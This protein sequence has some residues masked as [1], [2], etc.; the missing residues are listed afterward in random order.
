MCQIGE[1]PVPWYISISARLV[2]SLT[3]SKKYLDS[4]ARCPNLI[5]SNFTRITDTLYASFRFMATTSPVTPFT[6]PSA[7]STFIVII[8]RAQTATVHSLS[9]PPVSFRVFGVFTFVKPIKPVLS[10]PTTN[11][12]LLL[13]RGNLVQFLF[14][15]AVDSKVVRKYMYNI[16]LN[17]YN[18]WH[19]FL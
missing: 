6:K 15:V 11:C 18:Y 12:Y 5:L 16:T 9:K 17:N 1:A 19:Q 3:F 13:F 2:K 10:L 8:T 4:I 7:V 14:I